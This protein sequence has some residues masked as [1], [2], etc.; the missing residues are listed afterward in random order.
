[1]LKL[2]YPKLAEKCEIKK[3]QLLNGGFDLLNGGGRGKHEVGKKEV[4]NSKTEILTLTIN[5]AYW[6]I[7]KEC[8][9]HLIFLCSTET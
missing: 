1:M 2:V 7:Q 5:K 4:K 9:I 6:V 8:I 3:R